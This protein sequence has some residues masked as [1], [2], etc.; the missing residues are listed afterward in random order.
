MKQLERASLA[1]YKTAAGV[2]EAGSAKKDKAKRKYDDSQVRAREER[3]EA[4]KRCEYYLL[5]SSL[6][7]S[8]TM[9]SRKTSP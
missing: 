3:S 2:Q 1:K 4:T 9:C 5:G 8:L 6:R 7:S